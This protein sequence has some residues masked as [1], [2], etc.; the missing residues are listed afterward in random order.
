MFVGKAQKFSLNLSPRDSSRKRCR[1]NVEH[2]FDNEDFEIASA[3]GFTWD[4]LKPKG[5][6]TLHAT[7]RGYSERHHCMG[8]PKGL[9]N[10]DSLHAIA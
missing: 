5:C 9:S 2:V 7:R 8:K 4:F 3:R 10:D 1:H 6:I